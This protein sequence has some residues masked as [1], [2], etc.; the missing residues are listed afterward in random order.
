MADPLFTGITAYARE[1]AQTRSAPLLAIRPHKNQFMY[2]VVPPERL[3]SVAPRPDPRYSHWGVELRGEFSRTNDPAIKVVG[4]MADRDAEGMC[5]VLAE[6]YR[7]PRR[8]LDVAPH[9]VAQ[10]PEHSYV[11]IVGR[12][13]R[14]HCEGPNFEGIMVTEAQLE[15][16]RSY[17]VTGFT[18][19]GRQHGP[20]DL[21]YH[22]PTVAALEIEPLASS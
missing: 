19:P 22:G 13:Q 2:V 5:R 7:L 1:E 12:Y 4:P 17:R 6:H 3:V 21:G 8:A 11:T 20:P 16:G 10:L 18:S 15:Q 14:G 9:Q